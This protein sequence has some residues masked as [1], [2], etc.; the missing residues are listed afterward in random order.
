MWS[1]LAERYQVAVHSEFSL[2]SFSDWFNYIVYPDDGQLDES[3]CIE[4]AKILSSFTQRQ[5]YYLC[6][7]FE[8]LTGKVPSLLYGG[9]LKGILNPSTFV[10]EAQLHLI[11]GGLKDQSWCMNTDWDLSFTL[12]GGAEK[13]IE[14]L[15]SSSVLECIQVTEF[16]RIDRWADRVNSTMRDH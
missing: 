16:T 8:T 6:H 7:A 5:S 3:A 14:A 13:L 4:L 10:H 15:L 2:Y 1:E 9:N 11:I 12:V